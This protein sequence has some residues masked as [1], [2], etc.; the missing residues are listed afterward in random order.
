M[1]KHGR[2]RK[3]KPSFI[4]DGGCFLVGGSFN[5]IS[6]MSNVTSNEQNVVVIQKKGKK[7]NII[8]LIHT[9]I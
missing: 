3:G 2:T 8:Q 4:R 7:K 1:Y 6:I 9:Y 5:I